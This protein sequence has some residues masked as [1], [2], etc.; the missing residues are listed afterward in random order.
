MND[1]IALKKNALLA[2]FFTRPSF[3]RKEDEKE[4][5]QYLKNQQIDVFYERAAALIT[6][7]SN[8]RHLYV[9]ML[10]LME[11]QGIENE[12]IV[13]HVCW[14]LFDMGQIGWL[15][16]PDPEII[17][18]CR[19]RT[20]DKGLSAEL[21][22]LSYKKWLS[23]YLKYVPL[24]KKI[25]FAVRDVEKEAKSY[26]SFIKKL[27][28]D[29]KITQQEFQE[30]SAKLKQCL[31][32]YKKDSTFIGSLVSQDLQRTMDFEII[33]PQIAILNLEDFKMLK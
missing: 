10:M 26:F 18:Y 16:V 1:L 33:A 30:I 11:Q 3:L 19:G 27:Y 24:E 14:R 25:Q 31:T 21:K 23:E 28:T 2:P 12:H 29:K 32:I 13:N 6:S 15:R 20:T 7:S 9:Y 4:L 8:V 22:K 5:L 17:G